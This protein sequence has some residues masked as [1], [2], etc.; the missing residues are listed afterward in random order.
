MNDFEILES[1]HEIIICPNCM[2]EQMGEVLHTYPFCSYVHT[3][4]KCKY[5]IMESEW[6]NK[7]TKSKQG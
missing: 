4:T 6:I 5:V 1:H 2:D 7:P 3:C